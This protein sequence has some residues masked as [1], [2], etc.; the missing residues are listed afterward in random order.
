MENDTLGL[1]EKTLSDRLH[2]WLKALALIGIAIYLMYAIEQEQTHYTQMENALLQLSG[3][4]RALTNMLLACQKNAGSEPDSA[5]G[6][7]YHLKYESDKHDILLNA[8]YG[9]G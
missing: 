5:L 4:N 9:K 1:Q 3:R 7:Q 6:S 8:L 2:D